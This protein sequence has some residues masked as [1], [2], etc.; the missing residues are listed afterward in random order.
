VNAAVPTLDL[1]AALVVLP[2]PRA[3]TADAGEARTLN[4]HAAVALFEAGPVL[5]AHAG[6]TARRL[7]LHAPPRGIGIFDALELFAFVRPGQFCAPSAAGLAQALGKPEPKGAMAQAAALRDAAATLLDELAERP[8][9][10][11]EEALALAETLARSGWSWGVA[12]IAALRAHPVDHAWRGSG[13]DVWSRLTEW[14]DQAPPGEALS[15]PVEGAAAAE[16]LVKLL[17]Q[18]GLDEARPSQAEYA[19]EAA[20][21]FSPR[22]REGEPRMMLAEAGTG[23]GKT[24]AYLA[25]ASL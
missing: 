12:T 25:P 5:V 18:S 19:A 10:F 24:L 15:K 20:F 9:P 13:L 16:R 7:G 2:G 23:V 1:A 3:A 22:D 21:A 6:L 4:P 8:T 14:E 11:R 17:A